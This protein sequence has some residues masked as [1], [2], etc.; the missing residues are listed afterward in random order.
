MANNWYYDRIVPDFTGPDNWTGK[1]PG[2]RMEVV[3]RDAGVGIGLHLI[4]YHERTR[5]EFNGTNLEEVGFRMAF[6][7]PDEA[8]EVVRALQEAIKRA[9]MKLGDRP[10]HPSRVRDP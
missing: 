8:E 10:G 6:M 7:N 9:R 1:N 2:F 5:D 4:S 3:E